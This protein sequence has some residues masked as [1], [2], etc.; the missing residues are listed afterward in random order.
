MKTIKFRAWDRDK[1]IMI[2]QSLHPFDFYGLGND[3][4]NWELKQFIG[5]QDKNGKDVYVD[6]FYKANDDKI[7][8]VLDIDYCEGCYCYRLKVVKTGRIYPMDKTIEKLEY[9]GNI[10]E[11]PELLNES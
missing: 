5:L 6:F 9:C 11:N 7:R 8:Q 10:H 1:K 4:E 2:R 3:F